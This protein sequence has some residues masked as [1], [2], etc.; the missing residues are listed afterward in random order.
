MAVYGSVGEFICDSEDVCAYLER[1]DFFL[2]ANKITEDV[3][4]KSIFLSTVGAST[5]KLLRSLSNNNPRDETFVQLGELLK[6]HLSP[7]PNVIAQRFKFFK[8]DRLPNENIAQYLAE[9]RKLSEFCEFEDKLDEQ[10]RDKLVCGCNNERIQQKLLT[11]KDL[12]LKS[13][14]DSAIAFESAYRDTKK[15]QGQSSGREADLNQLSSKRECY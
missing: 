9:L 6:K 1:F 2:D 4:K 12:T 7:R 14:M 15:I 11:I 10:L 8:R 3:M 5:Y 13:A